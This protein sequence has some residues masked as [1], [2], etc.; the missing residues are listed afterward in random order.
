MA[1]EKRKAREAEVLLAA[2]PNKA[3][4]GVGREGSVWSTHQLA[5]KLNDWYGRDIFY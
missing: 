4:R 5:A 1:S 3:C 2:V